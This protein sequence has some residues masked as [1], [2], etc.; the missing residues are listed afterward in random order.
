M[1]S[2]TLSHGG[3][4]ICLKV[5]P[6]YVIRFSSLPDAEIQPQ[7]SNR[8]TGPKTLVSKGPGEAA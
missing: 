1:N 7:T 8:L 6:E 3:S 4:W 5:F 2:L